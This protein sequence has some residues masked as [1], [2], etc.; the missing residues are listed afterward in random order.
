MTSGQGGLPS[1]QAREFLYSG[2]S[3]NDQSQGAGSSKNSPNF[4]KGNQEKPGR[5]FFHGNS[6]GSQSGNYRNWKRS[7]RNRVDRVPQGLSQDAS[8][9]SFHQSHVSRAQGGFSG[10]CYFCGQ[11]GHKATNCPKQAPQF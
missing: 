2:A 5:K 1:V 9:G 3:R 4:S 6:G 7:M 8:V 11:Y 10:D